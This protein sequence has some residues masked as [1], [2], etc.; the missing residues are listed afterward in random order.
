[1]D[2]TP[3]CRLNDFVCDVIANNKIDHGS[4]SVRPDLPT[5]QQLHFNLTSEILSTISKAEKNFD[6][7]VAKHDLRVLAYEGYGKN[8]I[9]KLGASPDAYVQMII[10][11]AYYKMYGT[12]RSTYESAQTRKFQ[13]GRT[14]VCRT[15]SIDSVNWVKAMEDSQ[16]PVIFVLVFLILGL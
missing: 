4:P 1:M 15:V 6:D 2:G 9:K 7:L 12:S 8:V 14:E 13:H 11:L 16:V 10:Q 5:P 3:T